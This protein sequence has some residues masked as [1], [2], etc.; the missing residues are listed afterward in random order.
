MIKTAV[1][2]HN[3][4]DYEEAVGLRR[5]VLR[6]PLGL[7]FTREELEK[8][9][10]EIHFGLW[11][12]SKLSAVLALKPISE[13]EIKMRQVAVLPEKQHAGLGKILVSES[14]KIA[15]NAGYKLMTLHARENAIPFYLRLGYE[16]EGDPFTEV[17]IT[18]MKMRKIIE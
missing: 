4:P 14:E 15:V 17:G 11:N 3:S 1:I 5:I 6:L 8:E 9:K 18:H 7:D 10:D 13:K 12:D 2:L 16:L